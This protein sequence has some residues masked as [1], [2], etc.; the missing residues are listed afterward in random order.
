MRNVN[1]NIHYKSI[2]VLK[3]KTILF[4]AARIKKTFWHHCLIMHLR[5]RIYVMNNSARSIK[6]T[7]PLFYIILLY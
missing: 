1:E 7:K 6:K 4:N 3:H 5:I 2:I